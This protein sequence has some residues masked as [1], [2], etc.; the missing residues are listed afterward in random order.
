M[1][2]PP[3]QM[4][5]IVTSFMGPAGLHFLL[6]GTTVNSKL[7]L[8]MRT[9]S[10]EI[11]MYDGAPCHRSE[12]VKNFL[13]QKGIQ[14]AWSGKNPDLNLIEN[15]WNLMKKKVLEK[16]PTNLDSSS[17]F[18]SPT[19]NYGTFSLYGSDVYILL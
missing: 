13:E 3:S 5:W 12:V 18:V 7:E 10:C 14:M 15:S 17:K 19:H 4:I 16:H 8:I 2:H 9:H 11:F 1:K 6:S